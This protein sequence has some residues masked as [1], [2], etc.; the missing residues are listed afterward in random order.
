MAMPASRDLW[1]VAR[2]HALPDDGQRYEIIDGERFLMPAPNARHQRA[3]GRLYA[4][5]DSYCESCGL[6]L[7]FAPYDIPFSNDTVVEP[8]LLA[9]PPLPDGTTAL[10]FRDVGRLILAVEVLS[11]STAK[12][13][14]G[15]KRTVYRRE[16]VDEYWIVDTDTRTIERWRP[17]STEPEVLRTTMKWA[18]LA[19][20]AP[21]MIDV[22][23]YFAKAL[24]D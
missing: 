22:A 5:L 4:L 19:S 24:G 12:R 2:L 8:D 3:V 7:L 1:T 17:D 23:A 11:P 9:M 10:E 20:N 13:D 14:R 21:L 15:E 16:R 6:A 18:P